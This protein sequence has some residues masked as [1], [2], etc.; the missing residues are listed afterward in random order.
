MPNS[1]VSI[2]Q[3]SFR[4]ILIT[5]LKKG[6]DEVSVLPMLSSVLTGTVN[7]AHLDN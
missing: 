7:Y 5:Y 3:T 4:V 6:T 2:L 1:D